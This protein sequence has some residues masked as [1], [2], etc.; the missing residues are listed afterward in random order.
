MDGLTSTI[1][2]NIKIPETIIITNETNEGLKDERK[3]TQKRP[4]SLISAEEFPRKKQKIKKSWK[5]KKIIRRNKGVIDLDI[6]CGVIA[7]PDN[8]PCTRSLNCKK[9]SLASKRNVG[10]SQSYVILLI[11]YQKN[12]KS[13]GRHQDNSVSKSYDNDKKDDIKREVSTKED[14]NSHEK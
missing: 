13:I 12:K 8:T 2:S 3:K 14:N 7:P 11:K 1:S 10:R 4:N 9:H 5:K 6:Q